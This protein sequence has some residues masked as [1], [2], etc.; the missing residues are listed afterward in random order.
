MRISELS[1]RVHVS[2][3]TLRVWERRY[4]IPKPR[5]S[6][7]NA[8]LYSSLDEARIRLMKRYIEQEI[9][10]R[11]AAELSMAAPLT[12]K[13]RGD[14]QLLGEDAR[15][16]AEQMRAALDAFDE[17][18]A[19]QGLQAL[20]AEYSATVVIQYVLMPFLRELGTR[21]AKRITVAQEHFATNFLL[22][23]LLALARGWDR[24]LGPRAVLACAP[25]EHHTLALVAFGIALHRLGWRITYFGADTPIEMLHSVGEQLEP[26]LV[27]VAASVAGRLGPYL[28]DLRGVSRRWT[29]AV[30]GPGTNRGEADVCAA[31]HLAA[32]PVT[33]AAAISSTPKTAAIAS[34]PK[35]PAVTSAARAR[36]AST[37]VRAPDAVAG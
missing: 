1:R 23:R 34:A 6:A 29:L 7:G 26:E 27:V 19:D 36:A 3:D 5:R 15:R 16:A 11:Q 8:R 9:G 10:P 30:A 22:A 25:G 31:V 20:L 13:S 37:P 14:A 33:S 32:D 17:A 12:V 28:A 24:G 18:S 4:G 21:W 2:T 35:A